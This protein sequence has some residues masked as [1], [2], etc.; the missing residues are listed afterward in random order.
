MIAYVVRHP[1]TIWNI[2]KI[3]QGH[4]DSKLSEKGKYDADQL[5]R[6]LEKKEIRKIY[7]S[8]LGRCIETSEII[9]K[10][11]KIEM[12]PSYELRERNFGE[13]NGKPSKLIEQIFDVNNP[14]IIFPKG[15]SFNIMK[16]RTL[17]FIK[18]LSGKEEGNILLVT[19]DGVVRA[20]LSEYFKTPFLSKECNTTQQ[21]IGKFEINRDEIKLIEL[22]NK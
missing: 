4:K 6:K 2:K 21:F 12:M 8:D 15:E 9:N 19:H 18:N 17:S 16:N 20:I 5:G 11:L 3:A 22:I 1:Q 7:T 10:Y 13:Y 14:D